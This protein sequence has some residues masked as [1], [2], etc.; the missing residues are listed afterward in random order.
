M[1][2]KVREALSK[3]KA[4]RFPQPLSNRGQGVPKW[5][6]LKKISSPVVSIDRC[7][8]MI[9]TN[10][11]GQE[12]DYRE[13][14]YQMLKEFGRYLVQTTSVLYSCSYQ[15]TYEDST[16]FNISFYPKFSE[17]TN[18]GFRIEFNPNKIDYS[19]LKVFLG[20]IVGYFPKAEIKDLVKFNR[21]DIAIDYPVNL[22]PNLVTISGVRKGFVASGSRGIE[23]V[24][25]GH[26]SSDYFMRIYN[27][28]LELKQKQ[29]TIYEGDYLWRFELEMKK[30][31]HIEQ[32]LDF[33][34][35]YFEKLQVYKPDSTLKDFDYSS[36]LKTGDWVLDLVL[37]KANSQGFS[38][39]SVLKEIPER[40]RVRYKKL[41]KKNC[42]SPTISPAKDVREQFGKVYNNFTQKIICC[43][44]MT[45]K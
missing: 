14:E 44:A 21:L 42:S 13:L 19:V 1:R 5:H 27:K 33:I 34:Y 23:S 12:F 39:N 24:Y 45:E 37:Y 15:F 41:L 38:L 4:S 2:E 25:F 26:R 7:T 43:L 3:F 11:I 32:S 35:Q 6:L 30:D 10:E 20:K 36:C 28:K 18:Y 16:S 31:F 17:P 8:M 29:K 9:R 22:N 40:T